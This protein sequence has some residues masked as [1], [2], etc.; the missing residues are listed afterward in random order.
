MPPAVNNII[1][2]AKFTL[3]ANLQQQQITQYGHPPAEIGLCC[4]YSDSGIQFRIVPEDTV[5][6][7][8]QSPVG[9]EIGADTRSLCY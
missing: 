8:L 4:L 5:L 1:I 3:L 6:I 2:I 9:I 7:K